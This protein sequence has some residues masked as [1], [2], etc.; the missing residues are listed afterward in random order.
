MWLFVWYIFLAMDFMHIMKPCIIKYLALFFF[1][2]IILGIFCSI[3]ILTSLIFSFF[4]SLGNIVMLAIVVIHRL[5][6]W[7][8]SLIAFL[9]AASS[10]P[11]DTVRTS[12][13]GE[14]LW[15]SFSLI[16]SKFC[17]VTQVRTGLESIFRKS[18]VFFFWIFELAF[19]VI[20]E[21]L[22]YLISYVH[23][24]IVFHVAR[25][26]VCELGNS[27]ITLVSFLSLGYIGLS[28]NFSGCDLTPSTFKHKLQFIF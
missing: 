6:N 22:W 7:E 23:V 26:L 28:L 12:P 20:L 5:Y 19:L 9:L 25:V 16:F 27:I 13:Q 1:L 14:G 3:W 10:A 11:M 24:C 17:A 2:W 18:W 8:G 15:V 4:A 21:H